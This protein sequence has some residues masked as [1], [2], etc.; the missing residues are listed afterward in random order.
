MGTITTT[1]ELINGFD[2]GVAARG[3]IDESEVRSYTR[4]AS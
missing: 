4:N 1:I 3:Y 2:I